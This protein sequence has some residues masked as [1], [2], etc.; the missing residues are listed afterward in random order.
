MTP[1]DPPARWWGRPLAETRWTLEL[2][3]LLPDPV[4][5]GMG[6]PHGD[7]RPVLLLPGFLAGDATLAVMAGWLRRLGYSPRTCG[8]LANVDCSQRAFEHV[9]Q[10]VA[11]LHERH[12]RRVALIGHSRGGHLARAVAAA[13]PEQVSHA[14]SLGADLQRMF[15]VTAATLYAVAGARRVMHA[16]G[17]AREPACLTESCTCGFTRH[18]LGPFPADQVRFTSIYS[19]GDGVV[20]WERQIVSEADCVEVTGSHVGLIFNRKSYRA[21]ADAL[22]EPE[23]R[24]RPS[25]VACPGPFSSSDR[26]PP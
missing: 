25:N 14:I 10:R 16:T 24:Q 18:F 8:F 12:E 17:R 19:R 7:G 22:A 3:R 26:T 9:A 4:F 20:R 23:L 21:I 13:R 11:S 6:V 5:I 1:P 15:G 2:A